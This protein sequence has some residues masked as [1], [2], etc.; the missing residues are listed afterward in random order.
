MVERQNK[1]DIVSKLDRMQ[2]SVQELRT[3]YRPVRK[4]TPLLQNEKY[5]FSSKYGKVTIEVV[6]PTQTHRTILDLVHLCCDNIH[7]V[8]D[9]RVMVTFSLY[10]LAKEYGYKGNPRQAVSWVKDMLVDLKKSLIHLKMPNST[11][12]YFSILDEVGYSSKIE[13]AGKET[14]I[15]SSYIIYSQ[16]YLEFFGENVR[17]NY[18]SKIKSI[19]AC[20]PVVQAIIRHC[21]TQAGNY[22]V[23]LLKILENIGV[24]INNRT[25][26]AKAKAAIEK[27]KKI[28]M[29]FGLTLR[30]DKDKD[31]YTLYYDRGKTKDAVKHEVPRK[32]E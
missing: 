20:T 13:I 16:K 1:N 11:G 31:G 24:D 23:G 21:I 3:I 8:N 18:L 22:S 30:K 6:V 7:K 14:P 5:K 26:V 29:E 15:K 28:L 25:T 12:V 4:K 17:I 32:G 9:G 27:D 2:C 10:D 19:M